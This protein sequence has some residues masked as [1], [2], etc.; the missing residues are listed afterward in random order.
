MTGVVVY[1]DSTTIPLR[2]ERATARLALEIH[3]R[4]TEDLWGEDPTLDYSR[5][6][7]DVLDTT[8]VEPSKRLRGLRKFPQVWR[9]LYPLLS[10]SDSLSVER[11]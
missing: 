10:V 11:A 1:L 4:G 7:V 6:V 2:L 5:E 3:K 9:E 8:Y